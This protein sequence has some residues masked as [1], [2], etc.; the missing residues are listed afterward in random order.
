MST[1]SA[2]LFCTSRRCQ[3]R[4]RPP[5]QPRCRC[6]DCLEPAPPDCPVDFCNLHCTSPRCLVHDPHSLSGNGQGRLADE[7]GAVT[8]TPLVQSLGL[9]QLNCRRLWSRDGS[10]HDGFMGLVSCL[11]QLDLQVLC[12]KETQSPPMSSLP[13]D[14]P[15]RYDGP[16][17]S[18]ALPPDEARSLWRAHFSSPTGDSLFLDEF[19]RSVS[20]RFASLTSLHESGKFDAPFSY[21]ELVAALSQCHESAPSADCLPY[22]LFKVSFPWWRHLLLSLF[23]LVLRLSVV[24][25]A[26][27]SSLVV[28]V[29]KR[30]GDPTSLDSYISLASCAFK[31]FGHLIYARI[32]PHIFPQLD[33]SQGG[34]RWGA[35]A[36]AF[37]LVDTLRLRRHEHTFVAFIDIKKAFDY[38]WV[39]ATLVRLFDFGVMGS[40]WH[41]LANF[42]CGTLSQVRLGGSVSLKC[43]SPPLT[44]SVTLANSMLMTLSFSPLPKLTF[45]WPSMPCML[46]VFAGASPLVLVHL[47]GVPLP[48]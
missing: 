36:M 16:I 40:L 30:D 26:W 20:L 19:F 14:Q 7:D 1:Y 13:V 29:I 6:P 5:V 22:S 17:G 34:F 25:S 33:P 31:L 46:G 2:G 32:A 15:F 8:P 10:I 48:L 18:H 45:S 42:L 47:G 11:D 24:P 27:K 37:S 39:E 12:V 35:D 21:N 41:L 9:G 44:P 38:C 4:S 28:P 43:P 3:R 23:N